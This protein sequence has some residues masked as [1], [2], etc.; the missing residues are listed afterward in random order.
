MAPVAHL[1]RQVPADADVEGA[2]HVGELEV[3]RQDLDRMLGR[4]GQAAAMPCEGVRQ[5]G[6][7]MLWRGPDLRR[8]RSDRGILFEPNRGQATL[9]V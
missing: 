9:T 6:L 2:G 8:G 5:I 7:P 1:D 3:R 4:R